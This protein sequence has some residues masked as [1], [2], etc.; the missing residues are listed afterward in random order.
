MLFPLVTEMENLCYPSCYLLRRYSSFPE[1]LKNTFTQGSKL[2]SAPLNAYILSN[3]SQLLK[4]N[5]FDI[6][7]AEIPAA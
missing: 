1:E 6:Q 7:K 5:I 2:F 4:M 3:D